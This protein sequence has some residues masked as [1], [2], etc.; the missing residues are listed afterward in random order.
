MVPEMG[1]PGKSNPHPAIMA[2]SLNKLLQIFSA[3]GKYTEK[4]R[5]SYYFGNTWNVPLCRMCKI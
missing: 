3:S 2:W 4:K 1:T 5:D